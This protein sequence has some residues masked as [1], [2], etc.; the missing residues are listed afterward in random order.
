MYYVDLAVQ[1]LIYGSMYALMALGLTL[2]YG[3]LR[4]LHIA[5]AAVFTL[6]AYIGVV[7]ANATG[8]LWIAFPVAILAAVLAGTTI[9]RLVY[10]PLLDRPPLVPLIASVGLL[11][12]LEDLFRIA[13]GNQGI[14]FNDNPYVYM[15]VTMGGLSIGLLQVVMFVGS[16][17]SLSAFA[18]FTAFSRT[19]TAW[20]A[21]LGN[22]QM[23]T[24]FGVSVAQ[25]RYLNFAIGSAFA[26]LAGVLI[27]LLNNYAEPGMGMIVSYKALAIIVLGGLGSMRG[28]LIGSLLLG[29]IESYGTVYLGGV[30]ARDAIAALCLIGILMFR[31]EGLAKRAAA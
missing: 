1:G 11:I 29:V 13:F 7:I 26:G 3:L 6:G 17:A 15:T 21:T 16:V 22:P 5:H 4:V 24:S 20:R 12:L 27:A 8:S 31:P 2:I 14:A 18:L 25:V 30:V 28:A 19:G 23:A 9:Y 10:A